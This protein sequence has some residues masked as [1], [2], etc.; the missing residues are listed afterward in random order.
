MTALRPF[1]SG[2]VSLA[3]QALVHA[4]AGA[5]LLKAGEWQ[6]HFLIR[7]ECARAGEKLLGQ[8][9]A[10]LRFDGV[11]FPVDFTI[12]IPPPCFC[13]HLPTREQVF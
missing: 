8:R 10:P 3:A 4:G 1:P 6:I 11:V 2:S 13:I 7:E 12:K 9:A 5:R